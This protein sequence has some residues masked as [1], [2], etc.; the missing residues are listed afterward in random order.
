MSIWNNLLII[1]FQLDYYLS[2]KSWT[3]VLLRGHRS[4]QRRIFETVRNR[5]Y[6]CVYCSTARLIAPTWRGEKAC[7]DFYFVKRK[8]FVNYNLGRNTFSLISKYEALIWLP[9]KASAQVLNSLMNIQDVTWLAMSTS[10]SRSELI[11]LLSRGKFSEF[12]EQQKQNFAGYPEIFCW[13]IFLVGSGNPKN[14]FWFFL[15]FYYQLK[16]TFY[17]WKIIFKK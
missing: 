5:P 13:G 7:F 15:H 4:W 10:S 1:N 9:W 2:E 17:Q 16:K 3:G 8:H 12:F 11:Y 14:F 6:F